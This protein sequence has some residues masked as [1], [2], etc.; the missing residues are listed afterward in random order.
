L[1]PYQGNRG[2]SEII[3]NRKLID[4]PALFQPCHDRI[5]LELWRFVVASVLLLRCH[6]TTKAPMRCCGY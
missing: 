3:V 6:A 2:S 1:F 4:S 5:H